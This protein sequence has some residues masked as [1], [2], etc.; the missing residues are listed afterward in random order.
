MDNIE[1]RQYMG[2]MTEELRE[3][4]GDSL[5]SEA[6][7]GI[8]VVGYWVKGSK[9]LSRNDYIVKTIV[10]ER[11]SFK[12]MDEYLYNPHKNIGGVV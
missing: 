3:W 8:G 10:G 5:E 7:D 1:V 12:V 9:M 4:L 11:V 6:R 2:Y